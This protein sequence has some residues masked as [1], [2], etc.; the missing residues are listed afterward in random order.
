MSSS[1]IHLGDKLLFR[2]LT[3][4]VAV[5]ITGTRTRVLNLLDLQALGSG[6]KF[7]N[8]GSSTKTKKFL[9]LDLLL[10]AKLVGL[11]SLSVRFVDESKDLSALSP[12]TKI[13]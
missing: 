8:C 2:V 12:K 10:R 6:I 5:G 3:F 11:G 13:Q 4:L 1:E 9:H 7:L